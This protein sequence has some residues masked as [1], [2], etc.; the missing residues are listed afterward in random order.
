MAKRA[1]R[2]VTPA[3]TAKR[4]TRTKNRRARIVAAVEK[5]GGFLS[6]ERLKV[7]VKSATAADV[8]A[9]QKQRRI[10]TLKQALEPVYKQN[11]RKQPKQPKK[12]KRARR[13]GEAPPDVG[14]GGGVSYGPGEGYDPNDYPF[15]DDYA[16]LYD[17]DGL[18][19][20]ADESGD[21]DGNTGG[22]QGGH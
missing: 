3:L 5:A 9:L 18:D 14:G 15:P 7:Q 13:G 4:T 8:A 10:P 16:D 19:A 2:K 22:T 17:L 12:S 21:S 20:E 11:K 1:K 6:L